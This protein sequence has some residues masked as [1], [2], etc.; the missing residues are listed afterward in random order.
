MTK[1]TTSQP[2]KKKKKVPAQSQLAPIVRLP[3]STAPRPYDDLQIH[4]RYLVSPQ[5]ALK[6]L[7]AKMDAP[8]KGRKRPQR[9]P[10]SSNLDAIRPYCQLAFNPWLIRTV[11]ALSYGAPGL[12]KFSALVRTAKE[13]G[14]LVGLSPRQ[15]AHMRA[16]YVAGVV[17]RRFKE[18]RNGL[19]YRQK[20]AF[21]A[22]KEI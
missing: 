4:K 7:R 16:K 1:K 20:T 9:Q 11:L 8:A 10:G 14:R 5:R 17:D 2:G 3:R 22:S 13:V 15:V 12:N 21:P 19:H 6:A 18:H